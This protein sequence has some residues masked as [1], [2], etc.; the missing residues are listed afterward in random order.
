MEFPEVAALLTLEGR[1]EHGLQLS[2]LPVPEY[3]HAQA[4]L[5]GLGLKSE[6]TDLYGST[7]VGR[8]SIHLLISGELV[9]PG[10]EDAFGLDWPLV[11]LGLASACLR[12][13]LSV[14]LGGVG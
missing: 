5:W 4:A 6:A 10:T 3:I 1:T 13:P 9:E 8:I 11:A 2:V 12:G 7:A 14:D